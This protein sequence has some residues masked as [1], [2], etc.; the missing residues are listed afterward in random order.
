MSTRNPLAVLSKKG[1]EPRSVEAASLIALKASF[2]E[3]NSRRVSPK[4]LWSFEK[5]E[6]ATK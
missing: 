3:I 2:V 6:I 4:H 5:G 1:S